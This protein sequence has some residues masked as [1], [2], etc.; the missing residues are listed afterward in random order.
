MAMLVPRYSTAEFAERGQPIYARDIRPHLGARD[1]G[2]FVAIDIETG[3]M[4]STAMIIPRPN[5]C[6]AVIRTHKCGCS[7]WGSARHTASGAARA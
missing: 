2:K 6:C 5:G 7:G 3:R 4:S 1:N